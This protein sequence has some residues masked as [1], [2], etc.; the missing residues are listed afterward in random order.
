MPLFLAAA[1]AIDAL[2][3]GAFVPVSLLYFPHVAGL[4]LALAGILTTAGALASLPVPLLAGRLSDKHS[5][6]TVVTAG[7]L[8]QAAG[9]AG[10]LVARTPLTVLLVIATVAAGQRLF[11]SSLFTLVA[12]TGTGGNDR[13]FAVTGMLQAAGAGAGLL[14][15]GALL[16][17]GLYRP[18]AA[19]N[20]LSFVVAAAL[21]LRVPSGRSAGSGS[22]KPGR[23]LL[24]DRRFLRF[25]A[26]NGVFC[27][28]SVMLGVALP[29]YLAD[30]LHAASWLAGPILAA[31]VALLATGQL[32]AV[33]VVRALPRTRALTI[34][35]LLWTAWAALT[36]AAVAVPAGPLLVAYLIGV[37]VL[38]AAAE[39]IHAPVSNALAAEL[40]PEHARGSYL[41]VFQYG[42]TLATIVAP[43]GFALLFTADRLLPWLTL[44]ALSAV[45]TAALPRPE[46]S[47]SGLPT[48]PRT[49]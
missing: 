45:A 48:A 5:P 39:L 26:V 21:M 10:F 12:A 4:P 8:L 7:Q 35:G 49:G 47:P 17:T 22:P 36:A 30:G 44:A 29:V 13:R 24:P 14:T 6:R 41:A 33:R 25:T 3:T 27:L 1:I 32:G 18:L 23:R 40:A 19:A 46:L 9:F 16:A 11:W 37:T 20:A 15:A 43:A 28:C 38:Y 31:N 42:F 2:G 34:A